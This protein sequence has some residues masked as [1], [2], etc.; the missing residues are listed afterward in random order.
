MLA[1]SGP[2]LGS[3]LRRERAACEAF[4]EAHYRGVYRFF[5]WLAVDP[6]AAEDLTQETFACFWESLGRR[7]EAVSLDPKAWLYGI[8]R[9]R[10]RKRLRRER[11]RPETDLEAAAETP[12]L[13]QDP[14]AKLLG[15]LDAD[16][17]LAA[18]AA[19]TPEF[20]E[21][22]ALRVWEELSYAQIGE[23]LLITPGLARWRVHRA[24]RLLTA[25]IAK[26]EAGG[27]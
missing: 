7:S 20:R 2:E 24:R 22:L 14:E 21:A 12:D 26:E 3:L 17:A 27:A 23:A 15:T 18:M 9:N 5:C 6:T 10:W 16:S 13:H 11:S 8:A 1:E 25:R 19:L 4:V